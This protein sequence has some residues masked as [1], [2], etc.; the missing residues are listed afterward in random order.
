MIDEAGLVALERACQPAHDPVGHDMRLV[1]RE[2]RGL[3]W[4]NAQLRRRAEQ[5]ERRV[6]QY[7]RTTVFA[8]PFT[9]LA[10]PDA[11]SPV[12]MPQQISLATLLEEAGRVRYTGHKRN[13]EE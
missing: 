13:H 12:P 7:I 2:V 9:F 8:G 10:V 5:A 1:I 11:D 3:R 6:E 4:E